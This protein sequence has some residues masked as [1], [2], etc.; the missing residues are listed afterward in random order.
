[1]RNLEDKGVASDKLRLFVPASMDLRLSA[2]PANHSRMG[3]R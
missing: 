3:W 2:N 1:L